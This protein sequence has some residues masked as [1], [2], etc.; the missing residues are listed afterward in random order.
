MGYDVF[1]LATE[2]TRTKAE[3]DKLDATA[4]DMIMNDADYGRT[5]KHIQ[6][7]ERHAFR[8]YQRALDDLRWANYLDR[9]TH[10]HKLDRSKTEEA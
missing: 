4:F 2:V 7:S 1:A 10:L 8:Q 6:E 3:W 5:W 9:P